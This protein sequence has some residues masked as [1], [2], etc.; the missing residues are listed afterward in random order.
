MHLRIRREHTIPAILAMTLHLVAGIA[1]AVPPELVDTAANPDNWLVLYNM[2]SQESIS[3]VQWYAQQRSIPVGNLIGLNASTGEHLATLEDIQTQI[4]GPVRTLLDGDDELRSRIMGI[5]LGYGLPGHYS[6]PPLGGP[7]G[8]SV[9]DAL[10]DMY[11]DTLPPAQQKQNNLVSPFYQSALLPPNGRLT[12]DTLPENV[13]IVA[14]ID[15]P[16]LGMAYALTIRAKRIESP[17]S[18]IDTEIGWYDYT[19]SHFT[20]GVWPW[21][22]TAVETSSLAVPWQAFDS[23]VEGTENGAFRIDTHDVDGWND[24]RL[25]SEFPGSRIFAYNFNSWGATTVRSSTNEGGRFV[26]NAIIN[27]YAAALGATGEPQFTAP[28][29]AILLAG[30]QQGWTLGE[31]FFLCNPLNDWMWT[32]IGDPLLTVPHWFDESPPPPI[33]MG[34]INAD[35][36]VDGVDIGL[37]SQAMLGSLADPEM[38]ARADLSGDGL[39]NDDDA[40][41]ILGPTLWS[42]PTPSALQGTGDLDS[43]GRMDGQDLDLFIQLLID[44]D[45]S[46]WP[47][48]IV[49][50]ADMN[51]D[52]QLSFQDLP[53]FVEQLVTA[54][55]DE[56]LPPI[57]PPD[58]TEP[59]PE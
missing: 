25:A 21:L 8:F 43:N 11:D 37:L 40:F 2:N 58:E 12:R 20:N 6:T 36:S 4:V 22:R 50:A 49:W 48:R 31:S 17:G 13:Y 54:L 24:G 55:S 56:P 7:G 27:G 44:G 59:E 46:L 47:L 3:W 52:D 18:Y 38:L 14:R 34:D 51:L 5:L 10:Q 23:D 53:I 42:T 15:A 19:D 33:E 1:P 9:A 45:T 26:P 28:L 57:P 30:L 35:G 16:S 41:L 39:I 32:L 29:P